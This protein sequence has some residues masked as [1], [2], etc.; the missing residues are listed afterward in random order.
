M[1]ARFFAPAVDGRTPQLLGRVARLRKS[2]PADDRNSLPALLTNP[3]EPDLQGD[4]VVPTGCDFSDYHL[5]NVVNW[6]HAEPV[7]RGAVAMVPVRL[8]KSG[9]QPSL[10][11]TTTFFESARDLKGLTLHRYAADGRVIGRWDPDECLRL[12]V[13]ARE[14]VRRELVTGVSVEMNP[15]RK[16][17]LGK[18]LIGGRD[19]Y[20][21]EAWELLGWAHTDCPV[22]PGAQL[23]QKSLL[24]RAE[25][26]QEFLDEYEPKGVPEVIRK[27]LRAAVAPLL[28]RPLSVRVPD[29]VPHMARVMKAVDDLMP[30]E[31]GAEAGM[32]EGDTPTDAAAG[33]PTPTVKGLLDGS[34]MLIDLCDQIEATVAQGEHVKGKK[35]AA[36]VCEKLRKDAAELQSMADKFQQEIGGGD[37]APS[38]PDSADTPAEP[39]TDDDGYAMSKSLRKAFPSFRPQRLK[40]SDLRPAKVQKSNEPPAGVPAGKVLVDRTEWEDMQREALALHAR[41]RP[42]T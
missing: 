33:G 17:R 26:A 35:Y 40:L 31:P 5:D 11:G 25:K 1:R 7:G 34:Q 12:A 23:F 27:S 8:P 41:L 16:V 38:E 19:A 9:V 20:R 3:D 29:G 15:I 21:F 6:E 42:A 28:S 24:A 39:E 30:D 2:L 10:V 36:K 37:D 22:N 13:Q 14:L 18:S 32:G 4:E